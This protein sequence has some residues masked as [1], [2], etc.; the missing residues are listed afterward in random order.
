MKSTPIRRVSAR[1][2]GAAM[3]LVC[4]GWLTAGVAQADE[5]DDAALSLADKAPTDVE[6]AKSWKAFTEAAYGGDTLRAG[7]LAQ[8]NQRLS[9]D[10]QFDK[11]LAPGW[12]AIFADR[13]DV[14]WPDQVPDQRAINTIKEAYVSWQSQPDRIIDF[15]R[16]NVHEGVALGY[17]PTDFFR[18]GAVRSVVSVDPSSL[19]VNREGS[20]ML[21]GQ[22]L[23]D[24]GSVTALYSPKLED[25]A[26]NDGFSPDLGATNNQNRFLITA[27][28]KIVD[29]IN[30]QLMLYKEDTLPTQLGFNLTGLV[31]DSTVAYLEW[32][33]GRSPSSL[34]QALTQ[35]GVPHLDDSAFRNHLS[36]GLTYTT[37][38]KISLTAELEYD[39]AGLDQDNWDQLWHGPLPLYGLYRNWLQVAQQAPTKRRAFFYGSWQDALITHLDF[40]AMEYYDAADYSRLSWLE[41]RYHMEHTEFALQWQ[42][43]SGTSLSE[44]GAAPQIQGWQVVAR[45]YF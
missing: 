43:N 8:R 11:A 19:K 34:A 27:S 30:P 10:L 28:Q 38:N 3:M 36:T 5:Q 45:Y 1:L 4:A 33:G 32:S 12:R 22:T 21:R 25:R 42:R 39:G 9:F 2:A 13:L 20:V 44:Y 35:Q 24:G 23:W 17:N 37:A 7:D 16:I 15:G 41:A 14:D 26:S 31:N 6:Q 40:S 18:V 29:G